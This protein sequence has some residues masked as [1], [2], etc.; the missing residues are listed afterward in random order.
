MGAGPGSG[1]MDHPAST[2]P[3]PSLHPQKDKVSWNN[4]PKISKTYL[5]DKLSMRH[6]EGSEKKTKKKKINIPQHGS[7]S[8]CF[9]QEETPIGTKH[10]SPQHATQKPLPFLGNNP[11]PPSSPGL[12]N[13]SSWQIYSSSQKEQMCAKGDPS[14]PH[15]AAQGEELGVQGQRL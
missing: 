9:P 4:N 2:P 10:S 3:T 1:L 7:V 5:C 13:I 15:R 8:K 11:K 12:S 14:W 6:L